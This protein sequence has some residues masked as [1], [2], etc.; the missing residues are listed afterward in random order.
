MTTSAAEAV[1][2]KLFAAEAALDLALTE[3]AGLAAMLPQARSA[4]YIAATTGQAAFDGVAGCV[5]ALTEARARLVATHRSL[6]ALA[7]M[8]GLDA[9]A[10][11]PLD[12]PEDDTPPR[13]SHLSHS[14]T[15]HDKQTMNPA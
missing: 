3:A 12:K 8:R 1:A 7:R 5:S 13:P 6:A 15:V 9:L 11:G 2:V 4:A 10:A 14:R